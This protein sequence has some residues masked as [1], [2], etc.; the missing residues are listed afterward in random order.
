M[1]REL[2]AQKLAAILLIALGTLVGL[3]W[4]FDIQWIGRIP[5]TR[6][7]GLVTPMML[8]ACGSCLC[9]LPRPAVRPGPSELLIGVAIALLLLFPSAMLIEHFS[10]LNLGVDFAR[11]GALPTEGTPYPGRMSPNACLAFL[12]AGLAFLVHLRRPERASGRVFSFLLWT[13]L[14]LGASGL[15]GHLLGLQSLYRLAAA[16]RLLPITAAALCVVGAGLWLL[17]ERS[18]PA[19]GSRLHGLDRR[20]DRRTFV[21]LVLL[22]VGAGVS[23]FAVVRDTFERSA[24]QSL[25]T[26]ATANATSLANTLQTSL[27]FPRT[28]VTRPAVQDTLSQLHRRPE[29]P[30]LREFLSQVAESFLTAGIGGVR[31]YTASGLLVGSAGVMV[32]PRDPVFNDLQGPGRSARLLWQNGY[33]LHTETPVRD[34]SGRGVGRVVTQQRMVLFDELLAAMRGSTATSDAL[35]CS[36]DGNEAVCAPTRF[37]ATALHLPMF[38]ISGKPR[39]P[40]HQALLGMTG[41]AVTDDLRGRGVVAA[42][43]PIKDFGLGLVLKTDVETLFSPLKQSIVLLAAVLLGLISL[44]TYALRSQ[45]R[46]LLQQ[47]VAE[48]RRTSV[49]LEN[50]NDAFVALGVDGRVTDWNPEAVRLFGWTAEEAVGRNIADL[51][52]PPAQRAAHNEGF[53]RFMTTGTGPVLTRALEVSGL[54]KDGRELSVELSVA[55]FVQDGGYVAHAFVR[56][57]SERLAAQRR[58]AESE[59]HLRDLADNVPVLISYNDQQERIRFVNATYRAWTG[60]D[61]AAVLGRPVRE[62]VGEKLYAQFGHH[63]RA[64]LRGERTE[65][66]VVTRAR[67]ELR[68]LHTAYVP[69]INAEGEVVGVYALS[70]DVTETKQIEAQLQALARLD[71]LTGLPNRR[72]F[73]ERLQEALA[74]SRRGRRPMAL[75]FLD[76]D[77]FKD[78]NDTLG[79]GVGDAVL[80][81]FASRVRRCVRAT[82]TVARLAGDEFVVILEDLNAGSEAGP[83][84]RKIGAVL[85]VP[86][87]IDKHRLTVTSS[88]GVAVVEGDDVSPADLIGKADEA[89]Y[90]AKRAGRN[91][92]EVSSLTGDLLK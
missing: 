4:I 32:Q 67:G 65:F 88:I 62:I 15:L 91:T 31:F 75:M 79:H 40:I 59:K 85:E 1:K 14:A 64:A 41:V 73:D 27:W 86:F 87:L 5:T 39:L 72:A 83:V 48:Q 16:N 74:R 13:V 54:H 3:R 12:A 6:E 10:G 89:L 82:D 45:V 34:V 26:M 76:V 30:P 25:L 20:I 78:I 81:E 68:T 7:M 18:S 19:D 33:I 28:I 44:G 2:P 51:I 37:Y 66:E 35:I 42:Y 90:A 43:T 56:D 77:H 53:R 84:A 46:P 22:V 57:I 24:S 29:D 71:T 92:Y 61:P 47:I 70:T 58:Q 23:G 49:I 80:Q 9:L 11:A 38:D 69:D 60:I 8:V 63:L 17:R 52:I 21:A 50:A 55:S 36:R